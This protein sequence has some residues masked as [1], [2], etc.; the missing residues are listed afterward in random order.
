MEAISYPKIKIVEEIRTKCLL[1]SDD[2]YIV[3]VGDRIFLV[4]RKNSDNKSVKKDYKNNFENNNLFWN[5]FVENRRLFGGEDSFIVDMQGIKNFIHAKSLD[6]KD[7]E[8]RS[9]L[10][11]IRQLKDKK[12]LRVGVSGA[13]RLKG[14]PGGEVVEEQLLHGATGGGISN[15]TSGYLLNENEFSKGE[16]LSKNGKM[17]EARMVYSHTAFLEESSK[18]NTLFYE[19]NVDSDVEFMEQVKVIASNLGF[20]AFCVQTIIKSTDQT[21]FNVKGR[22]LKRKPRKKFSDL[23]DVTEIGNEKEFKLEKDQEVL[24]VGTYYN[25]R[26]ADWLNFTKGREY[27]R[28]GHYHARILKYCTN[29]QHEVFHLRE[30]NIT[31]N[32]VVP[33]IIT[34]INQIVKITPIEEK[35]GSY[36]CSVTDKSLNVL[37]EEFR[38]K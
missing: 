5:S 21:A 38:S 22:V 17:L 33:F 16:S 32:T 7:Y 14:H 11:E 37:V 35:N 1:Y 24:V 3:K 6:F 4:M 27:E 12:Y 9:I 26:D 2:T 36:F 23:E 20:D 10:R 8:V 18:S 13:P 15:S 34:P 25:R 28:N 29:F 30:L 31:Q 19:L